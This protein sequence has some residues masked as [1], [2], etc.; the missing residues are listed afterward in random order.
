MSKVHPE[1]TGEFPKVAPDEEEQQDTKG[2]DQNPD[3]TPTPETL[4]LVQPEF[5]MA[6]A[7]PQQLLTEMAIERWSAVLS[8]NLDRHLGPAN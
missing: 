5:L 1:S 2:Q 8:Y 6:D 7:D 3:T 4:L